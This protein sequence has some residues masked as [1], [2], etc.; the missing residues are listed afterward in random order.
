MQIA[1]QDTFNVSVVIDGVD[2]G[3][4]WEARSGGAG[5]SEE[6]KVKLGNM[7]GEVSLGGSVSVENITLKKLYD[8]DGIANNLTTLFARRGKAVVSITTQPLD[9]DGNACGTSFSY[10]GIL[11]QVTPPEY[12]AQGND[13]AYIELEVSTNSDIA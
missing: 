9:Y 2:Y 6:T 1:R 12:D 7:G 11:K 8:L 3:G 5:D 10:S 4:G 13:E